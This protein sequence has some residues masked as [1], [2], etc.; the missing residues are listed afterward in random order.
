METTLNEGLGIE[1]LALIYMSYAIVII[2][3]IA[4]VILYFRVMKYL[5]LEINVLEQQK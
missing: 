1:M 2:G 3:C 5:K 4:L